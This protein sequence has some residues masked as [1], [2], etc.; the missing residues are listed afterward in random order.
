MKKKVLFFIIHLFLV[1]LIS[2]HSFFNQMEFDSKNLI[3]DLVGKVHQLVRMPILHG[4]VQFASIDSGYGFYGGNVATNKFFVLEL[5]NQQDEV[6]LSK[7][8]KFFFNSQNAYLRFDTLAS[9]LYNNMIDLDELREELYAQKDKEMKSILE[10]RVNLQEKWIATI[11]KSLE[12]FA[13]S[14]IKTESLF[15]G[16]ATSG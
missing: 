2:L 11:Y 13:I 1:F 14:Q 3:V 12:E 15:Y 7:E 6:L 10:R 4:Y 9:K 16:A 8:F 5:K